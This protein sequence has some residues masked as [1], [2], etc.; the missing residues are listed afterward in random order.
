MWSYY[1]RDLEIFKEVININQAICE[2]IIS[3]LEISDIIGERVQ[4]RP[5]SRGFMGLCPFHNEDTPSFH[6]YTDTQT[7]YCF[8]CHEAGNIFS[9]LMKMDNLS[10]KEALEVLADRAGIELT[11]YEKRSGAKSYNDILDLTTKFFTENL[12]GIQGTAARAYMEQRKMN[13]PDIKRFSLGYSLNSWDSLVNYLRAAKIT[14]KHILD[15]GLALNNRRG[16]YDRFRGRLMFPIKNVGGKII[17][18]GGRLIDGEGAKYINSPESVVYSKRKNLYLLYEARNSIKEKQRSI[19]VEGYMDAIRLHKCG[20]TETVASLGTSLTAEQAKLLARFAN[21]CYICYDSDSAGQAATLRGMYI[22]QENGLNVQVIKLPEGKDPDEFLSADNNTPEMFEEIIKS[23]KPLILHHIEALKPLLENRSTRNSAVKELFEGLGKLQP[24][25]VIAYKEEICKATL[26][27]PGVIER[28][29]SKS[30]KVSNTNNVFKASIRE[31]LNNLPNDPLEAGICSM[32][33]HYAECRLSITPKEIYSLLTN[34]LAQETAVAL[35]TNNPDSL[36]IL[37]TSA[38][39]N[40]KL[41]LLEQGEEFCRRNNFSVQEKWR[42]FYE[43][44]KYKYFLRKKEY[45][46]AKL[47]RGVA[48]QED[49]LEWSKYAKNW[50]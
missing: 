9:F 38:N 21:D 45:L 36:Y 35:I 34:P 30:N 2:Q 23:A 12:V 47:S 7:Y 42:H 17:A 14:D 49:S 41:A 4:L 5:S 29:F 16:L 10:F 26:V 33:F 3:A 40:D 39:E 22:L 18:F 24:Q 27:P 20:F 13:Q 32:L 44:L 31:S 6:V 25:E 15:L 48:S 28:Q 1:K 43:D 8:G 19:L 37:W 11:P 50:I 46:R